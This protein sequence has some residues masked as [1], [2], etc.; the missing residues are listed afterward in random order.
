MVVEK[1]Y[2]VKGPSGACYKISRKAMEEVGIPLL[3]DKKHAGRIVELVN[4]KSGGVRIPED[5]PG[6]L[7][8]LPKHTL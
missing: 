2:R 6:N 1:F 7:F 4:G 3:M 8:N 5:N